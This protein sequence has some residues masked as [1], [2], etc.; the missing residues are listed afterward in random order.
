MIPEDKNAL[1]RYA[2]L[3]EESRKIKGVSLGKDAWRRLRRNRVSMFSLT[4]LIVFSALALF[5]PLLP[6]QSPI[7]QDLKLGRT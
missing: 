1:E 7:D 6:L 3:L 5:T 4:L 2:A